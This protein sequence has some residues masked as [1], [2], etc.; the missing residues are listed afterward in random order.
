M[1][2][3]QELLDESAQRILHSLTE[4]TTTNTDEEQSPQS[5]RKLSVAGSIHENSASEQTADDSDGLQGGQNWTSYPTKSP[6][7]TPTLS[8]S[9]SPTYQP[10]L[11]GIP[12]TVRGM[13]WYDANGNGVRD[14]N[15]EREGFTDVEYKFGVGGVNM[16]LRECD[17]ETKM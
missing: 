7:L 13:M 16:M 14:S 4:T 12:K 15:V 8:P 11:R 17:W 5:E 1:T 10:T 2:P 6:T 9:A 3:E